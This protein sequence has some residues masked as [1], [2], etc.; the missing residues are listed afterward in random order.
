MTGKDLQ[1]GI[2]WWLAIRVLIYVGLFA[3]FLRL[4]FPD[5]Q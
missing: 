3:P 4:I 1:Y 5:V 2:D